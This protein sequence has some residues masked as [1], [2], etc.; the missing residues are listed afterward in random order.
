MVHLTAFT[1]FSAIQGT[2][3]QWVPFTKVSTVLYHY[4]LTAIVI[5]LSITFII[6]IINN[7]NNNNNNNIYSCLFLLNQTFASLILPGTSF[8]A[9][10]ASTLWAHINTFYCLLHW[11]LSGLLI[12]LKSLLLCFFV[13]RT[14][15]KLLFYSSV[16][17]FVVTVCGLN[18]RVTHPFMGRLM[19]FSFKF[20]IL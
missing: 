8:C 9:F 19:A 17:F 15:Y 11:Y 16:I 5:S 12:L 4:P 10:S 3:P 13:I 18:T 14:N 7:N 6:I 2:L 1:A 20:V